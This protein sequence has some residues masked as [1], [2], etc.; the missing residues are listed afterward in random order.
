MALKQ[1]TITPVKPIG[2]RQVTFL[3]FQVVYKLRPAITLSPAAA[4]GKCPE[5][6]LFTPFLLYSP[7]GLKTKWYI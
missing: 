7:R 4:A 3:H 1:R 6:I 2:H 5:A